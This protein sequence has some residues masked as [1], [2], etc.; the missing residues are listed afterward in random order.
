MQQ[1]RAR[2][3]IGQVHLVKNKSNMNR[4]KIYIKETLSRIVEIKAESSHDALEEVKRMYW[5]SEIVLGYGDYDD[6]DF[7]VM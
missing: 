1:N 4:Y 3:R 7:N 5:N 2:K 6:V